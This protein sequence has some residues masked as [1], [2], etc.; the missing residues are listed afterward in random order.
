MASLLPFLLSVGDF[1]F[2]ALSFIGLAVVNSC[3]LGCGLG[4]PNL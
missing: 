2:F 3:R 1:E 4:S